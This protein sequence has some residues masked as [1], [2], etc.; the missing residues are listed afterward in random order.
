[1]LSV[2]VIVPCRNEA[3][4][5]DSFLES[6]FRQTIM[7]AGAFVEVIVADGM[8]D[9]GTRDRLAAWQNRQARLIVI[10]NPDRTT[11]V[12][13]NTAIRAARG[14]LVVRMDVHTIYADDYVEQCTRSLLSTDAV[15]VGGPWQ[16]VGN[17]GRH[18][19]IAQAFRSPFGSGGAI[20]RRADYSG[21]ADTVYLG[22]WRRSDL[23]RLGGFDESLVRNQDDEL[24]LRIRRAGGL[25]WQSAG[26]RSWYVPRSSFVA[27][28]RQFYQYGYWK[29]HVIRK[30]RL[31][32]SPRHLV[33]FA[34]VVVVTSLAILASFVPY[35]GM[36]AAGTLCLYAVVALVGAAIVGRG[37][38]VW[39]IAWAFAC[40]HVG[41]G[42]G[43]VHGTIHV[44]LRRRAPSDAMTRLTR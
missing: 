5:I 41:Y 33:P 31:P 22:A 35:A 7:S 24:N 18:G 16:P 2:S 14:E 25:V 12:A 27:L 44:M 3:E 6:V 38:N 32:A 10:A 43:F 13:L 42:I 29:V 8:S 39:A 4:H 1:M 21:P 20:S 11:S 23:L 37:R 30:H 9:D 19:A 17:G 28:F 40:M 26:I 15:C 34:F 36:L